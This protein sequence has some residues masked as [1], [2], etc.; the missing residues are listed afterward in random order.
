VLSITLA[1]RRILVD[2]GQD[3]IGEL[4]R[5]SPQAIILTHAHSDHAGGLRRG[6]RCPVHATQETWTGIGHYPI[7]RRER[8]APRAPFELA[9]IV[10]EAFPV[11]HSLR[12]PAVGYRIRHGQTVVFYA[13]DLVAIPEQDEALRG[14][15]LYIGDGASLTRSIVRRRDGVRI[16]HASIREQLDWCA[17]EGVSRAVFTHCGSQIVRAEHVAHNR[18]AALG[19]ERGVRAT[20]AH[21]G[22][23]IALC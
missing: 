19:R 15:R 5:F 8:V 11:E 23:R 14:I 9:G 3:W 16:G 6:A 22:L 13:P 10:F 2:F 21:D 7:E 1:R 20:I 12:A 4:D 18:V 17:T